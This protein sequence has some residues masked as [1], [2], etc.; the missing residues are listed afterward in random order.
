[1]EWVTKVNQALSYI[2]KNLCVQ[3][4]DNVIGKIILCPVDVLQRFFM[5]NTGITLTEYIRRRKLS[6]AVRALKHTDEKII[7]IAFRFGYGSSDAFSVAFKRLYGMTPRDARYS[8]VILK[9]YPPIAFSLSIT[10]IEGD[11]RLKDISELT[12]GVEAQEIFM[13]PDVRMIGKAHICIFENDAEGKSPHD[14][15][16]SDFLALE[17]VFERLPRVIKNAVVCWTGDS[18]LGSNL[19]TYMPGVICPAGTA[20]PAGFDFRDLPASYVAKGIYGDEVID[21]I[22]KFLPLGFT[23]C[24]TDLGWN[25]KLFLNEDE[26]RRHLNTPCRWLVPCVKINEV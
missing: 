16:W 21:V 3:I 14:S 13:M 20:V 17:P 11:I 6:E 24:Y 9:P 19:Y 26:I 23:T 18:P 22:H 7:D 1:M 10:Y 5:L 4:D 2:E 15:Y 8:D 12:L 25:A